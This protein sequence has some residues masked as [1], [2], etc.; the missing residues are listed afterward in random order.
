M[1]KDEFGTFALAPS[2]LVPQIIRPWRKMSF[3]QYFGKSPVFWKIEALISGRL[4][5]R[6]SV[7]NGRKLSMITRTRCD[8]LGIA[9]AVL[10][11][12]WDKIKR[13]TNKRFALTF[14]HLSIVL[15]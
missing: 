10:S 11:L 2:S 7:Q 14:H 1:R 4:C 13:K 6:I 9:A 8:S 12:F 5:M 15:L 3:A